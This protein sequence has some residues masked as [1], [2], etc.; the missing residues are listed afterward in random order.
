LQDNARFTNRLEVAVPVFN[1]VGDTASQLR[2]IQ[3]PVPIQNS[4]WLRIY[5][6]AHV[7]HRD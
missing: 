3:S 1:S 4:P 5:L 2:E 7:L 6:E